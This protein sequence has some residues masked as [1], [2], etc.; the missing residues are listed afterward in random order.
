MIA[1]DHRADALSCLGMPGVRT[2]HLDA[3]AKSGCLLENCYHMGSHMPAVCSPA[4]AAL[5]TGNHPLRAIPGP[6]TALDPAMK[7]MGQTF[8]E[9]GYQTYAVGKWHNDGESLNRSFEDGAALFMG[10]MDD[11]FKIPLQPYSKVCDYSGKDAEI[12]DQHST[13][14]FAEAAIDFVKNKSSGDKP[15]F[16]YVAFTSPHDPRTP[17]PQYPRSR[18]RQELRLP[19]N[20][21]PEHP[22][23]IGDD[24]IRDELLAPFPRTKEELKNHWADY[25]GMIEH[26]DQRMGDIIAAVADK[27]ELENTIIVYTGDHGLGMGSHGLLGKQNVY[28]H[29]VKVPCIISGPG[30]PSGRNMDCLIQTPDL[31]PTLCELCDLKVPNTVKEAQSFADTLSGSSQRGREYVTSFYKTYGKM[32]REGAWK[33]AESCNEDGEIHRQLFNLDEDPQELEDLIHK[34]QHLSR[35]QNLATRLT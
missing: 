25:L 26:M 34:Q 35:V 8:R 11:H 4:R 1:D 28:E 15:W 23:R 13:D 2:P 24:R 20:V 3:L 31:Y 10:G 6:K 5:H 17:P 21:L 16:L 14:R 32:V 33:L 12:N 30:I 18:Y 22:W 29:S 7:T 27:G 19:N 9:S